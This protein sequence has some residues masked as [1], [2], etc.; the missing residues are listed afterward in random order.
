MSVSEAGTRNGTTLV[1]P[2]ST[3]VVVRAGETV[4]EVLMVQ[5]HAQAAFGS[6]YAFPGGVLDAADRGLDAFCQGLTSEDACRLL[7]V[8]D[9]GLDYYSAA[10]REL[11]EE[12]GVLLADTR[13]ADTDLDTARGALN[14]GTLRWDD[15]VARKDLALRCDELHY[16]AFWITPEGAPKRFAARF[17]L[18]CA[19]ENQV[20]SHCGGELIDVRW[21]SARSI[22]D[23][24]RA[25]QIKLIYPTRKTLEAIAQFDAL[26]PLADWASA[27]ALAG[28]V[29][30]RPML[31]PD[32]DL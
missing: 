20:A 17:F 10:I 9:H 12:T 15:F 29:C 32:M 1:R 25:K 11:F 26:E 3:V 7:D 31:T 19:P 30:D 24:W 27:C 21:M 4:P 14:A 28:V 5:R 18:A 6:A 16:F 8:A 23:A 22:L 2:A 13:I